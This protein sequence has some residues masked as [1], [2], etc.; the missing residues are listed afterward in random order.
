MFAEENLGIENEYTKVLC[1]VPNSLDR[2]TK[3]FSSYIAES[4]C[5]ACDCVSENV[6]IV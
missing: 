1:F 3:T 5:F 6:T 2:E 4:V